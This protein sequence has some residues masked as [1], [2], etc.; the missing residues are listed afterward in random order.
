LGRNSPEEA[1]RDDEVKIVLGARHGDMEQ[2]PLLLDLGGRAGAEIGGN[3]SVDDV[4]HEKGSPFLT[5]GG[6]PVENNFSADSRFAMSLLH[7]RICIVVRLRQ[8]GRCRQFRPL[9]RAS[10]R[11]TS[12]ERS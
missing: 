11:R 9:S 8:G 10:A 6:L 7:S 4:E 3:A 5:L 1:L 2:A 12:A